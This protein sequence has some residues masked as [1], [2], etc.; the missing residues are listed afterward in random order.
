LY[1]KFLLVN[2]YLIVWYC[3]TSGPFPP[4][5]I[6]KAHSV[7]EIGCVSFLRWWGGN[8]TYLTWIRWKELLSWERP[9]AV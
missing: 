4:S 2:I 1:W 3:G 9:D 6:P 7:L 8:Y 5:N